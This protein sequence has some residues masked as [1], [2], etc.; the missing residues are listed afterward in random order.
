MY[1]EKTAVQCPF[2]TVSVD[3][4]TQGGIT[5]IDGAN[6][7]GEEQL[8]ITWDLEMFASD[9]LLCDIHLLGYIE[10]PSTGTVEFEDIGLI[11]EEV[12]CDTREF[13]FYHGSHPV[14]A[15]YTVGIFK[16]I[17]N[18]EVFDR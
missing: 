16:L 6:W 17:P 12:P 14:H 5:R 15:F 18:G 8:T 1:N 3:Q 2:F 13:T 9:A 11:G 7:F 4:S 10:D